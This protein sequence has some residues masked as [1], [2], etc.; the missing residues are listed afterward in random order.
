MR[1]RIN[2][3]QAE[4]ID[5]TTHDSEDTEYIISGWKVGY[6]V[7]FAHDDTI[8]GVFLWQDDVEIGRIIS[9]IRSKY[10]K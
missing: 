8:T 6:Q 5:V 1:I 7:I 9:Y 10:T 3:I 2:S 4:L